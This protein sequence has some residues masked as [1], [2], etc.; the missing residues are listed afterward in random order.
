MERARARQY[1]QPYVAVGAV[2]L[3]QASPA[4]RLAAVSAGFSEWLTSS[5]YG[6]E[7][8]PERLLPLLQGVAERFSSDPRPGQLE[9]MIRQAQAIGK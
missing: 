3:D 4:L 7:A 6:A 5:P 1:V 2:S 8:S 9:T